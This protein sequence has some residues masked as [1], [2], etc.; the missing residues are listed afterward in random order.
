M[1]ENFQQNN[2]FFLKEKIFCEEKKWRIYG[3]I[4][5]YLIFQHAIFKLLVN[6]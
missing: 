4:Q 6:Y 3:K 2:H 5:K 1:F